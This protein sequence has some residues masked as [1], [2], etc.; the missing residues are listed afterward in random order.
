MGATATTAIRRSE[1][2][3]PERWLRRFLVTLAAIAAFR[4]WCMPLKSSLWLDEAGTYWTIKDGLH[5][6][7]V[8]VFS[9]QTT[10]FP[11]HTAL[12]WACLKLPGPIEL[13]L[14]ILSVI[15]IPLSL[16]CYIASAGDCSAPK[17]PSFRFA[18]SYPSAP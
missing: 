2:T 13:R 15:A 4:S 9:A 11:I 1:A 14:R 10:S 7:M 5:T 18:Y 3:D 16:C 8:R 12:E 6:A 17:R